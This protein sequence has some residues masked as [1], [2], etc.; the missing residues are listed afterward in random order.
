MLSLS[1]ILE[2]QLKAALKHAFPEVNT[3]ASSNGVITGS[4][5]VPTSKT[6]FGDFQSNCALSLARSLG[7]T[8]RQIASA[9]V[10]CLSED[11]VFTELCME[12]QIAGPGFIN[13]TVR[14]ERLVVEIAA[15]LVDKRLGVLTVE[16]PAS[17]IVDFSSPNIAKEMHV[18]IAACTNMKVR[19]AVSQWTK[20]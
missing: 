3:A 15:R 4:Q 20:V 6:E 11:P 2:T 9:I 16:N 18:S 19:D 8:P 14:P 12:P 17:V 5:L 1:R 13:I 10:R 7:K